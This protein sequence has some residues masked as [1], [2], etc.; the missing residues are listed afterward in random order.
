[1]VGLMPG[2]NGSDCSHALKIEGNSCCSGVATS[3]LGGRGFTKGV[4]SAVTVL[5]GSSS[6]ADACATSIAN[7]TTIDDPAVLRLPAEVLDPLTDIRGQLITV[8]VSAL[9]PRAY[10]KAILAGIGRARQLLQRGIIMGVII[11]AGPYMSVL[12]ESLV[13]QLYWKREKI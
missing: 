8:G 12:P 13:G 1:M 9:E 2:L 3:G 7:H 4:A 6:L 11:C 10:E 5:A